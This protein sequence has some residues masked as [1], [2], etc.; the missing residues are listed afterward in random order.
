MATDSIFTKE[1]HDA[2]VAAV[3][4]ACEENL[5]AGVPIFYREADLDIKEMPDGRKFEIRFIPH[6]PDECNYEVV[7]EIRT[8][9]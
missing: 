4:A 7:R 9:A 1:F 6:A 2:V 3:K 5:R 8:A